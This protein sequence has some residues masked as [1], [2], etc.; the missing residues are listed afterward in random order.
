MLLASSGGVYA[1]EGLADELVVARL[2]YGAK[3]PSKDV[4][5]GCGVPVR[6]VVPEGGCG[7]C[8]DGF[9]AGVHEEQ[10]VSEASSEAVLVSTFGNLTNRDAEMKQK[11]RMRLNSF[12]LIWRF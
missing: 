6:E 12:I 7:E 11:F 9:L 5:N 1:L 4:D 10:S 8:L 3:D 2:Q